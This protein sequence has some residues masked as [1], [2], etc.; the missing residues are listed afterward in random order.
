[1]AAAWSVVKSPRIWLYGAS[2]FFIKLIRYAL[3]FWLPY[4]LTNRFGYGTSEA[5][6]LSTAFDA[7]GIAGVIL[8]GRLSDRVPWRGRAAWALLFLVTL[9]FALAGYVRFAQAGLLW[10]AVLLAVVGA[11][12][13][14]P[15]AL[16]SGAAAQDAGGVHAPAMATGFVNGLGSI[17][18]LLQGLLVPALAARLGWSALFPVFIVLALCAAVALLPTLRAGGAP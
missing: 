16:L 2:Y 17:G 14:G 5:A 7:G 18:A 6:R 1:M 11:L 3:L 8:I 9:V 10:H 13:F 12:L 4:Y 15:D